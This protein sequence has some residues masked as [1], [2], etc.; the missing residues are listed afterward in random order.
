MT[1]VAVIILWA[2]TGPLFGHSDT[3]QL[4]INTGTTSIIFLLVFLL[5][6]TQSRD[7]AAVQLKLDELIRA[8]QNARNMML[9]LEDLRQAGTPS[10]PGATDADHGWF[11]LRLWSGKNW[12]E[13]KARD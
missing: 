13:H 5:Q 4:I 7:T 2:A 6:N 10:R 9:C 12:N 8:N 3:W 1:A 11:G